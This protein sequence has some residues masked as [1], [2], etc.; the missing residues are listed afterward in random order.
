MNDVDDDVLEALEEHHVVKWLLD[1]LE[2]MDSAAE[3]FK[4]KVT[5]L[6]ESVRHHVDEEENGYFPKVRSE[7][8]RN[9]LADLGEVMEEAKKAAPTHPHPQAPDTPP[10]NL[11][12][13]TAAGVVDRL[14]D[15]AARTSKATVRSASTGAKATIA[16]ATGATTS[17]RRAVKVGA[18]RTAS[19]ATGG[20][21]EDRSHCQALR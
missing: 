4:A 3:R 5:V 21:Q 18:K 19:T 10:G 2:H 8:G 20:G 14:T 1:E 6:I 12:G 13:G 15:K 9:D 11:V 16:A 17:T 7:L